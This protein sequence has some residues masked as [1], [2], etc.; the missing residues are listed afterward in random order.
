MMGLKMYLNMG[1][2]IFSA[3]LLGSQSF[4][5]GSNRLNFGK[6]ALKINSG[7][8]GVFQNKIWIKSPG[9]YEVKVSLN[10]APSVLPP[11]N[12]GL[13]VLLTDQDGVI[14]SSFAAVG[15]AYSP[16]TINLSFPG[17]LRSG[18]LLS[19]Q[20]PTQFDGTFAAGSSVR[21]IM[22]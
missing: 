15:G 4:L 1:S 7:F 3:Q 13:S 9:T 17:S 21:V 6:M 14:E 2:V 12:P 11:T 22:E 10:I 5:S 16:S 18:R 20:V 19:I 8:A